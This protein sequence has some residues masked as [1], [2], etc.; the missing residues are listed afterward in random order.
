MPVVAPRNGLWFLTGPA[1]CLLSHAAPALAQ[2]DPM[3]AGAVFARS[4]LSPLTGVTVLRFVPGYGLVRSPLGAPE[5]DPDQP[6]PLPMP[7]AAPVAQSAAPIRS[8]APAE[9][10]LAASVREAVSQTL[11][12]KTPSPQRYYA[13]IATGDR[14]L[15]FNFGRTAGWGLSS[16]GLSLERSEIRSAARAGLGWQ[17]GANTAMVSFTR[18]KP[19]V[20]VPWLSPQADD[21]LALTYIFAQK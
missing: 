17:D 13:F 20:I 19:R 2:S 9:K 15:G 21:R 10:S 8:A 5:T 6:P 16:Q 11:N 3:L 4:D 12:L 18:S 7:A 1:L 14:Q